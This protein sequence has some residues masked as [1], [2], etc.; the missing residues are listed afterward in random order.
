VGTV[1]VS[2]TGSSGFAIRG[3]TAYAYLNGLAVLLDG[4]DI[5][6][7]V[8]KTLPQDWGKRLGDGSQTH[9]INNAG[10]PGNPGG[11]GAIDVL[12]LGIPI[13]EGS[14]TLEFRV[15]SGGGKVLY[16]LYVS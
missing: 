16:N 5:T 10:A 4:R 7:S 1:T 2:G 14:H 8:V 6:S 3:G 12:D 15:K 11:T 9:P 13:G